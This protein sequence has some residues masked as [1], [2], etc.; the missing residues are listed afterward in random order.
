MRVLHAYRTYFPDT[1]GGLEEVIRQICLNTGTLGAESRVICP[2]PSPSHRVVQRPEAEVYRPRLTAEIASCSIS[3]SAFKVFRELVD[4]A[5][6]VHYHFP[7]PFADVLHFACRVRKPTVLTYHSDI[8]RQR[9]LGMVYGPLMN[10]FLG[11]VDRI[12][13]TSPNYFATS[14]VLTRFS[15]KVDVVPIGLDEASYPEPP[16]EVMSATETRYGRDFFLFVGVLRY[17]KG[18][19]ILLDSIKNAP[20]RVVI[21]G[22]GPTEAGLKRQAETLALDNVVFTGY[23]PDA[24]KLSLFRLCRGVVFPSYMRSEAFGVTLLEGAMHSRP[25][26]ST[27]VGSGTSH[28]NVDGQTGLVVPPGSAKALRQAMD[29]LW[30]R[31]QVAQHMGRN[32]RERFE[33]LFT[34][35]VMGARYYDIYQQLTGTPGA[36]REH[37]SPRI[38]L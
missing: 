34:G 31:P 21:V 18:L 25:L 2:S 11:S 30:H 10:R 4:W 17:Y 6:V 9:F 26:I 33:R 22:S 7:W 29:Q 1:Q 19:H 35:K 23:L 16:A 3:L 15:D 36:T 27:E 32:A 38:G 37:S 12:V 14:D 13:C 5:D 8:V 24:E 28:V 20:Y